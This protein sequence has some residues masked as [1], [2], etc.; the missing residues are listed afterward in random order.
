V[1]AL[2]SYPALDVVIGLAFFYFLLSIVSSSINEGIASVFA[3]RASTLE[4]GIRELLGGDKTLAARF[5]SDA[6]V[7]ALTQSKWWLGL[8][9][10]RKPSYIPSRVFA[11]A[12]LDT[13]APAAQTTPSNAKQSTPS[14]AKQSTPSDAKGLVAAPSPEGSDAAQSSYDLF[15]KAEAFASTIHNQ[16]VRTMLQDALSESRTDRDK[17]REALERQFDEAMERVSGW[18][19]RR[20]QLILFVIALAV[21][22][23]IN[24]DSFTIGQR[25]WKDDVVRSAVVA[26]AQKTVT[27]KQAECAKTTPRST[28]AEIAGKC[29]DQVKQ[30]NLPLGWSTASS[31]STPEAGLAKVLGLLLTAFALLLGAPFWFDTLSKLA[32]LRGTGRA[33]PNPST[34]EGA[35]TTKTSK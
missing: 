5:Y 29:F 22:A 13:V 17:F 21:C 31:P 18:Y 15:A 10:N 1:L 9:A 4:A 19:K 7:Q 8:R 34:P 27:N 28:S 2:T 23:A 11:L 30:L 20:V 24:A 32:Q 25:L 3:L 12:L 16:Q 33:S 14:D 26:Q 6:R 35:T